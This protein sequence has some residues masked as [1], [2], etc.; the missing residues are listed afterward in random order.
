MRETLLGYSKLILQSSKLCFGND[1][2]GLYSHIMSVML[3][4]T[5]IPLPAQTIADLMLDF[6]L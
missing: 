5:I 6:L 3:A 4:L 2:D 1:A